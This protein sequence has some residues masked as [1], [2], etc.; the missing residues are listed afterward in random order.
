MLNKKGLLKLW[1]NIHDIAIQN[2][3]KSF[4]K[5]TTQLCYDA[6]RKLHI[7]SMTHHEIGKCLL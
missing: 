7:A 1:L 5:I 4:P 3:Y 6:K 2:S